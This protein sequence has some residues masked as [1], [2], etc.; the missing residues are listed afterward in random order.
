MPRL[1][2]PKKRGGSRKGSGRKKTKRIQV[3][4]HIHRD[5]VL[6][7]DRKRVQL[8]QKTNKKKTPGEV[9]EDKFGYVLK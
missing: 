2:K 3:T 9:I 1:S 7:I 8:E 6:E 5:V 4:W